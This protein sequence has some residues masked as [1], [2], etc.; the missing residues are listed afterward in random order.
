MRNNRKIVSIEIRNNNTDEVLKAMKEQARIALKSIGE[1]AEGYAKDDCPVDS[2]RLRNSITFATKDYK[3]K[4]NDR[5]KEKASAEERKKLATPE[6]LTL[7]LGTNVDYAIYVEYGQYKHDV[8]K[9]HFIRDSIANHGDHY[10]E[11]L[12]AALDV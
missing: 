8:G 9:N 3:S 2:G 6:D 12:R 5:P 7:Y 11:I 4:G 10:K 1:E